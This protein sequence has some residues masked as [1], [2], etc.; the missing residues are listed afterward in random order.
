M[1][2]KDKVIFISGGSRGIGLAIAKKAALDGAKIIIAAKTAEPH[3]KLPGTIYT[4]AEEIVSAGLPNIK[5]T[6]MTFS[7]KIAELKNKG[8]FENLVITRGI[9]KESLRVTEDGFLSQTKHPKGLGSPLT[10]KYITTDFSEA[11]VELVTPTFNNIDDV[12]EFLL[13]LHIFTGKAMKP[14]EILWTNSM[15]CLLQMSPK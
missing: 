4:A 14:D 13:D 2:L 7:N 15:P 9:E 6:R 3:P 10:N 5:N 12:Y 1:S 8:F 11:L